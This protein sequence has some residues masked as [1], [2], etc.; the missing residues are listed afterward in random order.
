MFDYINTSHKL[1]ITFTNSF[2]WQFLSRDEGEKSMEADTAWTEDEGKFLKGS[3]DFH[4]HITFRF[5]R[6]SFEKS[7]YCYPLP[8]S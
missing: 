8:R 3:L 6:V 7:Y 1:R 2:Q 5:Q 4:V